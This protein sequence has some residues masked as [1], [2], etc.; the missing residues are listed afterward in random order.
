MPGFVV[1]AEYMVDDGRISVELNM[2][3]EQSFVEGGSEP[4]LG[5]STKGEDNKEQYST[6]R[7]R[8]G[9]M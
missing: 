7:Q 8:A 5:Q 6:T 1:A 2:I 3:R 4:L 9:N